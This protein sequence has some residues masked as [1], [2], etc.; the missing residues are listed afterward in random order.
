VTKIIAKRRYKEALQTALNDFVMRA[1][2]RN[3][4]GKQ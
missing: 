3:R 1:L 2:K 4:T